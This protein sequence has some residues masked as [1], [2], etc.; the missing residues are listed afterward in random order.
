VI[1]VSKSEADP[2]LRALIFL[3]PGLLYV[4]IYF[5]ATSYAAF[6]EG[7]Y[8]PS[9]LWMLAALTAWIFYRVTVNDWE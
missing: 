3:R 4:G 1:L 9:G 2:I 8:A 7:R 5:V 6:S